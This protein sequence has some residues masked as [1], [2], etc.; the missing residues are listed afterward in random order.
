[1]IKLILDWI[2]LYGEHILMA[3]IHI[4]I[5]LLVFLLKMFCLELQHHYGKKNKYQKNETNKKYIYYV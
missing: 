1:M 4:K 2:M 3:K 5:T